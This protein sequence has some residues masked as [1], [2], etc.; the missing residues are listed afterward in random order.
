MGLNNLSKVSQHFSWRKIYQSR[1]SYFTAF[2]TM[3]TRTEKDKSWTL[4]EGFFEKKKKRKKEKLFV[5]VDEMNSAGYLERSW[6]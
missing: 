6:H 2:A 4:Y 3:I 1:Y 5:L